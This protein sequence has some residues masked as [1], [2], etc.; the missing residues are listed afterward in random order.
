MASPVERSSK[1]FLKYTDT[2]RTLRGHNT[3]NN[4]DVVLVRALSA[5]CPCFVRVPPHDVGLGT[6]PSS[7]R[8]SMHW[9]GANGIRASLPRA[10]LGCRE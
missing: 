1:A 6:E 2:S 7:R 10:D 8:E 9:P 3:D 4:N 5:S